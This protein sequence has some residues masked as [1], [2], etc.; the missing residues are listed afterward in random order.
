MVAFRWVLTAVLVAWGWGAVAAPF[1]V[2]FP[3]PETAL[4][5]RYEYPRALVR[6]ALEATEAD[7][8]PFVLT[9]AAQVAPQRRNLHYLAQGR[10]IDVTWRVES[11][12]LPDGLE[13]VLFAIM[14]GLMGYRLLLIR[15]EKQ[16][17]FTAVDGIGALGR[18][19]AGFGADWPDLAVMRANGL[20]VVTGTS[21]ESLFRQLAADRFDYFSRSVSEI[22]AE[23]D[24]WRVAAPNVV[25]EKQL[26]LYY[27]MPVFL[28]ARAENV[29]LRDRLSAGLARIVADGRFD[30]LF[31]FHF[32]TALQRADLAARRV[33]ALAN[34]DLAPEWAGLLPRR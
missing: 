11:G 4:D 12:T 29:A 7:F 31:S 6:L 14:K 9:D 8:G 19:T 33:I 5:R 32:N 30:R 27:P 23:W 10:N 15:A 20:P 21:Y 28:I 13:R 3:R 16:P 25:V 24:A 22:W 26:A 1:Q 34:P 17:V 18:L 2:R